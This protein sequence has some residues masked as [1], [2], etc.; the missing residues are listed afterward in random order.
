[1]WIHGNILECHGV[2]AWKCCVPRR[3]KNQ[4]WAEAIAQSLAEATIFLTKFPAVRIAMSASSLADWAIF[5]SRLLSSLTSESS[6][7]LHD[8]R[9]WTV[10]SSQDG[11][12]YLSGE[13]RQWIAIFFFFFESE[14]S[15]VL[16]ALAWTNR[17]RFA[18]VHQFNT[19]NSCITLNPRSVVEGFKEPFFILY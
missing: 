4:G 18:Q 13:W 3:S 8:S 12:W 19:F 2:N 15:K 11:Q 10:D 7:V 17:A 5:R 14:I 6:L 1:M 16:P 9:F